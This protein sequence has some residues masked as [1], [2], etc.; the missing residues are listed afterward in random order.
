MVALF[1][2][3][4]MK[5]QI[6]F[7]QTGISIRGVTFYLGTVWLLFHP[8]PILTLTFWSCS[9]NGT[10]LIVTLRK[11]IINMI[12]IVIIYDCIYNESS[13]SICNCFKTE[14]NI[15]FWKLSSNTKC[16]V[17]WCILNMLILE[18]SS[19]EAPTLLNFKPFR[20]TYPIQSKCIINHNIKLNMI[21]FK[22]SQ[23]ISKTLR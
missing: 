1:R 5:L 3:L 19:A 15:E 17:R 20:T 21:C 11:I 10:F 23:F 7:I 2:N 16:W 4:H 18:P 14:Q 6:T 13:K 9:I 12:Y 22:L 8:T